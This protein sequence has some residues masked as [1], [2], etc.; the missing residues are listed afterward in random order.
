MIAAA[1]ATVAIQ[2][3]LFRGKIGKSVS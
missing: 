1:T 3:S 2:L